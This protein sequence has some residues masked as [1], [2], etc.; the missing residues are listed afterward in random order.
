MRAIHCLGITGAWEATAVI[1]Q[2]EQPYDV[3]RDQGHQ[4]GSQEPQC[5]RMREKEGEPITQRTK[6]CSIASVLIPNH[7][8]QTCVQG[9]IG[10]ID[11]LVE[12]CRIINAGDTDIS[13]AGL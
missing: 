12:F 5:R 10:E 1:A 13:L 2:N 7:D 8:S 6:L 9:R 11:Y 4:Q 3:S